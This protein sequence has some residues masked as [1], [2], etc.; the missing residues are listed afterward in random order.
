M[1][2]T[3]R[4]PKLM[5]SVKVDADPEIYEAVIPVMTQSREGF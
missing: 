1:T 3:P 2:L 5:S 4:H